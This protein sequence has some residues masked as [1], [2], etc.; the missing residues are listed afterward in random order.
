MTI[1]HRTP[2]GQ[3][4]TLTIPRPAAEA[5]LREHP[6]DTEGPCPVP[7]E[8]RVPEQVVQAESEEKVEG[9]FE[10]TKVKAEKKPKSKPKKK[11]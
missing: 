4:N 2:S 6:L 5:H 9:E 3:E 11:A 7:V 10:K 1:C 8:P